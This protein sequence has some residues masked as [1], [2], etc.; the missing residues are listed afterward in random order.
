MEIKKEIKKAQVMLCEDISKKSGNPY[1]F[2]AI[3]IDIN[4]QPLE[5]RVFPRTSDRM[6]IEM[7]GE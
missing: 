6:L 4:G 7:F 2:I 5:Y 3:R 1:Q